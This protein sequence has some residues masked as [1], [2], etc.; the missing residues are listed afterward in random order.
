MSAHRANVIAISTSTVKGVPKSNVLSAELVSDWGL[1]GDAH[2]GKWPRQVSLLA[3][4]SISKMRAKGAQVNPGN[5]AENITTFGLVLT[6]LEIGRHLRIGQAELEITQIGKECHSRCTIYQQVGDCVM[7]REGV[8]AKV[9][10][11]GNIR[12]GDMITVEKP[13][14]NVP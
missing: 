10:T 14:Q 6:D 12:A 3:V 5:F 4:E 13:T 2:A 1:Q 7:P 9:L 11:G 8:F